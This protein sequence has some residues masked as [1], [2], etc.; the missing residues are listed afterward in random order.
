MPTRWPQIQRKRTTEVRERLAIQ[1][2]AYFVPMGRCHRCDLQAD[3][4]LKDSDNQTIGRFCTRCA[5]ELI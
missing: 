1:R 2:I 3:G 4:W 5:G